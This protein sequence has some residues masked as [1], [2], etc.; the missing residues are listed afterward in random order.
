MWQQFFGIFRRYWCWL[1]HVCFQLLPHSEIK[2]LS[3]HYSS[4]INTEMDKTKDI[5]NYKLSK[6]SPFSK[7]C[8]EIDIILSHSFSIIHLL[9][10]VIYNLLPTH[11][12]IA[13]CFLTCMGCYVMPFDITETMTSAREEIYPLLFW[14]RCPNAPAIAYC[15]LK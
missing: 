5:N 14:Y 8:S 11:K 15:D 9:C 12:F 13:Y 4:R 2:E 7:I 6:V 3:F 10:G 1:F